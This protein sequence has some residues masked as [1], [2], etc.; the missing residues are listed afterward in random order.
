MLDDIKAHL[1]QHPSGPVSCVLGACGRGIGNVQAL[2]AI[3][4]S[5]LEL[6]PIFNHL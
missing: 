1:T 4:L 6:H 3:G 5:E 2:K